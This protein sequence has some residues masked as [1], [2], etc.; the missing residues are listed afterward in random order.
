[1]DT[2]ELLEEQR[3]SLKVQCEIRDEQGLLLPTRIR[4]LP[5]GRHE[6]SFEP[7]AA[8]KYKFKKG[9]F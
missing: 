2:R 5:D 3:K 6:C 7:R 1:M 9:F 8:G 4:E